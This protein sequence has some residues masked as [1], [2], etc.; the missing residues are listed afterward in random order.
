ML[1]TL[2]GRVWKFGDEIDTDIICPMSAA[3]IPDI[4]L[5]KMHTMEPVRPGWAALV[6]PGDVIVAGENFGCGSSREMAPQMIAALGIR[7][8]I[9]PSFGRIFFRNAVNNGI[10]LLESAEVGPA[11]EEGDLLTVEVG[12]VIR[13]AGREFACPAVPENI[14]D[15]VEAGGLVPLMRRKTAGS[16][17]LTPQPHTPFRTPRAPDA[18]Q[19]LHRYT[20]VEKLLMANTGSRHL[21]PGDLV[22]THPDMVNVHEMNAAYMLDLFDEMGFQAPWDP[23]KIVLLND[24]ACPVS[25]S[26]DAYYYHSAFALAR[27][28]GVS[29][30]YA[31]EGVGHSVFP[32]KG[33]VKPGM[34]IFATDSHTVSYGSLGTFATGIGYTEMTAIFGT[35]ELWVKVPSAVKI[36]IDGHLPAGVS[37]KDVILRVL[38]DLRADGGNYKSLEFTGSAVREM[39]VSARHTMCNMVVEIGAK[40]GICEA[41]EKTAAFAGV[42][43]EDLEWIRVGDDDQYE[44]V[45]RYRAEELE[46]MIACPPF[47]DNV[48]PLS[49]VAGTRLTQVFFG[50]CTNSSLED[51]AI[52]A[53]LV[54]GKQFPSRL[55]VI[56]SPATIQTCCDAVSRGYLQDIVRAGGILLHPYCGLC[57][58]RGG[59]LMSDGEVML[60]TNNRNFLGRFGANGA[61]TYLASPAVAAASALTGEITDPRTLL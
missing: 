30:H 16:A 25:T 40:C 18:E 32:E 15:I 53:G 56:V 54:R 39:S 33:F 28:L 49:A 59:G 36:V 41:D 6:R 34:V 45:L 27:K 29:Q 52:F 51:I 3:K 35:G 38:G 44:R 19:P 58:G 1:N 46:P 14:A 9:A 7:V 23:K 60:G 24:H 17:P 50:S 4:D 5:M 13:V 10:L 22:T 26:S 48:K 21:K 57:G 42:P 11:C 8:I 20:L 61:Q 2:E 31:G 37:S 43:A 12:R 55:K 47:V